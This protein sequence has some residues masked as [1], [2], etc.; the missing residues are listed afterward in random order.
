MYRNTK[1]LVVPYDLTHRALRASLSLSRRFPQQQM[2][3][4]RKLIGLQKWPCPGRHALQR[5]TRGLQT[6]TTLLSAR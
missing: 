3:G 1:N 2:D 4:K 6:Q 5:R